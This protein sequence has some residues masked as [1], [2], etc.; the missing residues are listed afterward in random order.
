MP[1]QV[2]EDISMDFIMHLPPTHN[3]SAIWVIVDRLTKFAHFIALPGSFTA[4]TLAPIF[5]TE[6]YRLHGAPKTI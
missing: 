3:R 6:V 1:Q 5:I 2:W 4:A